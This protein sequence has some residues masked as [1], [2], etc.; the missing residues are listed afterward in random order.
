RTRILSLLSAFALTASF[1][2]AQS[3]VSWMRYPAIS[4][5]GKTIVFTFKGDLYRVPASGGAATALTSHPAHDFMPVWSHDGK[6]IA[7]A[8]DRY[9]NFDIFVIPA[10]GGESRRLTYHSAAEYPYTF[11]NDDK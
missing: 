10:E 4:P 5:D 7:F 6:Q 3:D 8:S 2:T 11:S 1:V 9:G